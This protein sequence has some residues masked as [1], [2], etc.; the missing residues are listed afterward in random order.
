MKTLF[1]IAIILVGAWF[2]AFYN[3]G[4][5]PLIGHLKDIYRSQVVQQ[6]MELIEKGSERSMTTLSKEAKRLAEKVQPE[7]KEEDSEPPK[8]KTTET[9]PDNHTSKALKPHSQP[10]SDDSLTEQDRA[11][12]KRLILEKTK[13]HSK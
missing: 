7:N 6:K 12:L 10:S 9:K 2:A 11:D 1:K 3:L 4:D 13:S 8:P 5:K